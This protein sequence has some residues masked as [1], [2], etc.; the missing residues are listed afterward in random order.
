MNN[1]SNKTLIESIDWENKDF[2]EQLRYHTELKDVIRFDD[3]RTDERKSVQLSYVSLALKAKGSIELPSTID[4]NKIPNYY[5]YH[6]EIIFTICNENS[7]YN[8]KM[9]F[10]KIPTN[11]TISRSNEFLYKDV[12]YN[13]ILSHDL[14]LPFSASLEKEFKNKIFEI[15]SQLK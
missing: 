9:Y 2:L 4:P 6:P 15:Y 5:S 7:P 8:G 1:N 14:W 12:M 13:I 3:E 11:R 10:M